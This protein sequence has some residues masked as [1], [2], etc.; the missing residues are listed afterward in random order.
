M[1][2]VSVSSDNGFTWT[3]TDLLQIGP[4]ETNFS[5]IRIKIQKKIIQE[6]AVENVVCEKKDQFV[7]GRWVEYRSSESCRI[8]TYNVF[9]YEEA[10]L[11]SQWACAMR[12]RVIGRHNTE[13]WQCFKLLFIIY[14]FN[15]IE[16][17]DELM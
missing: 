3:S 5:E 10:C 6:N 9:T 12:S 15:L 17:F 2:W 7:Q 14:E 13:K 11:L 16:Y 4:I 1:N 8:H